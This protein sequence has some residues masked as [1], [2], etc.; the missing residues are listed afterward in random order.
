MSG[1]RVGLAARRA[2]HSARNAWIGET[3]GVRSTRGP[4]LELSLLRVRFAARASWPHLFAPV[5]LTQWADQES[6]ASK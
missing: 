4:D 6:R 5:A 3:R 2:K 1:G